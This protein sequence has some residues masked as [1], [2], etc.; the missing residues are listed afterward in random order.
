MDTPSET[1]SDQT[2]HD[3]LRS[4]LADLRAV[5]RQFKLWLGVSLALGATAVLA[6]G[7]VAWLGAVRLFRPTPQVPAPAVQS[8]APLTAFER[9]EM[10]T[11]PVE[12]VNQ[13]YTTGF[14][15]FSKPFARRPLVFL[16]EAGHMGSFLV[17]KTDSLS[18]SNFTWAVGG[19]PVRRHYVSEIAWI[20]IEP[21]E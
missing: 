21:K 17:C 1:T 20:A 2:V 8:G 3:K 18:E 14:V 9:V 7:L 13:G 6:A 15:E 12:L 10:G 4:E 11:I 16:C 19:V 5:T